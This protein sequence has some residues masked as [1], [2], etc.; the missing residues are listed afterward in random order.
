MDI[1]EEKLD[2]MIEMLESIA[3]MLKDFAPGSAQSESGDDLYTF[4]RGYA[5]DITG[6]EFIYAP[7]MYENR[8]ANEI[9]HEYV[10][11]AAMSRYMTK[12][13]AEKKYGV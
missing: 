7:Y 4:G 13:N 2:A 6:H 1:F 10:T 12:L 9:S 3:E 8:V 11:E 5:Q